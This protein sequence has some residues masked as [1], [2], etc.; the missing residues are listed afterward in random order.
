MRGF[1]TTEA[2]ADY[3]AK[4]P[5]STRPDALLLADHREGVCRCATCR[6]PMR[7]GAAPGTWV[8][9]DDCRHGKVRC[10]ADARF[11]TCVC[12]GRIECPTHGSRC[13]GRDGHD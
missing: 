12:G 1:E 2:M 8:T 7:A 13:F 10:C 9:C 3:L 6:Q 4:Y 11:A 5:V